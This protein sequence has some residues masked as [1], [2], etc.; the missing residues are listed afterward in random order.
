[1]NQEDGLLMSIMHKSAVDLLKHIPDIEPQ[2]WRSWD[3]ILL[4]CIATEWPQALK[5]LFLNGIKPSVKFFHKLATARWIDFIQESYFCE[6]LHEVILEGHPITEN[7]WT[8]VISTKST[9]LISQIIKELRIRGIQGPEIPLRGD[10]CRT[11]HSVNQCTT[12]YHCRSMTPDVAQQLY[13]HG[14]QAIDVDVNCPCNFVGGTPLYLCAEQYAFFVMNSLWL[15]PSFADSP[16]LRLAEWF[17]EKGAK[18]NYIHRRSKTTPIHLLASSI[19]H[20]LLLLI[21][22]DMGQASQ[23]PE[24]DDN[25]KFMARFLTRFLTS[26]EKDKCNCACSQ[27]GCEVGTVIT[28]AIIAWVHNPKSHKEDQPLKEKVANVG[29]G[30]KVLLYFDPELE[31][32]P[33]DCHA[34]FRALTFDLLGL[35][36][37]C[38]LRNMHGIEDQEVRDIQELEK[39]DIVLL[40]GLVEH[41][42]NAWHDCDGPLIDFVAGYWFETVE[43]IIAE[44]SKPRVDELENIRKLGVKLEPLGSEVVPEHV[45]THGE[46]EWFQKVVHV[47]EREKCTEE[48][49]ENIIRFNHWAD[50]YHF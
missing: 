18:P 34:L 42:A 19:L 1:M 47:I 33:A 29:C 8:V 20:A 38:H 46:W 49:L 37:T 11:A 31:A 6:W 32:R 23:H 24:L 21:Y 10:V 41:F 43:G 35:T 2:E 26:R 39:E 14:I 44:R 40:D 15:C 48:E 50:R 5:L 12:W 22:G 45:P 25:E 30:I 7:L 13:T 16:E 4:A 27:D 17:I 28:R 3:C 36:H 9:S